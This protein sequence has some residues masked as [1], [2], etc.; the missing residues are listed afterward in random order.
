MID[1]VVWVLFA[2]MDTLSFSFENYMSDEAEDLISVVSKTNHLPP[3]NSSKH[4]VCRVVI[5]SKSITTKAPRVSPRSLALA[6][7]S[8]LS[9]ARA[10]TSMS[11]SSSGSGTHYKS[12]SRTR[13]VVSPC[14]PRYILTLDLSLN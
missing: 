2:C 12:M 9:R 10:M 8:W 11:S 4:D 5:D 6:S 1:V 3:V 13:P 7:S 14:K